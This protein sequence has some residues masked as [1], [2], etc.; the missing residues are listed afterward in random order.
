MRISEDKPVA[1]PRGTFVISIEGVEGAATPAGDWEE[2]TINEQQAKLYVLPCQLC[3][4]WRPLP[5]SDTEKQ[6]SECCGDEIIAG[7]NFLEL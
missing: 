7:T 6:L 5:R 2:S 3:S 4:G 1:L